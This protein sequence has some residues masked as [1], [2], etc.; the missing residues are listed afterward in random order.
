MKKFFMVLLSSLIVVSLVGCGSSTSSTNRTS[1]ST[2][3]ATPSQS[4]ATTSTP[5]N[6]PASKSNPYLSSVK[7]DENGQAYFDMSV[8]AFIQ[9]YNSTVSGDE[10]GNLAVFND[11]PVPWDTNVDS[12]IGVKNCT[13]Y[14]ITNPT[15][16]NMGASTGSRST[17]CVD[18]IKESPNKKIVEIGV[19]IPPDSFS[20]Q[21]D[22]DLAQ[23]ITHNVF[24]KEVMLLTGMSETEY[25]DLFSKGRSTNNAPFYKGVVLQSAAA[26]DNSITLRIMPV[27]KE[28]YDKIMGGR[29]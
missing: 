24:K 9:K 3:T 20:G 6:T 8:D 29:Q 15:Q 12:A 26:N 23:R 28:R 5:N 16:K 11:N 14:D 27:T 25:A 13:L 17:S 2:P 18:Y 4:P 10:L 7:L 19:V 1:T 22:M 21:P